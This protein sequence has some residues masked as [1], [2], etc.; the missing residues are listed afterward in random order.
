VRPVI[1]LSQLDAAGPLPLPLVVRLGTVYGLA[2]VRHSEMRLGWLLVALRAGHRPAIAD[3]VKF[4][5][6]QGRMKF[7]RPLYRCGQV[8]PPP[9]CL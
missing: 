2:S 3:A 5:T 6:E 4:A 7:V 1:F 8:P 9:L